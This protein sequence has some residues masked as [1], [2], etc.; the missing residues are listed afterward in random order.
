MECAGG[1]WKGDEYPSTS[2]ESRRMEGSTNAPT[3][4]IG[5][6]IER[7]EHADVSH[8]KPSVRFAEIAAWPTKHSHRR[9]KSK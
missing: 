9:G 1:G 2:G 6:K 8:A 4:E 3:L 7:S 5:E